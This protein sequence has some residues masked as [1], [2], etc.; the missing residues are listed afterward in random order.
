MLRSAQILLV[1]TSVVFVCHSF[2]DAYAQSSRQPDPGQRAG[3]TAAQ[4]SPQLAELLTNWSRAS[5]QIK[6]LH[7]RHT[8]RVYDTS[9][10]V[11]RISYGE[12]WFEA[13]DKGRIDIKAVE[14]TPKMRADRQ[15]KGAKVQRN[16][17]GVPFKLTSDQEAKWICDGQRVFD[18][19]EEEK[20]AQIANLP[21]TLRGKDI[22][23]SPLPFLFGMPPQEAIKRF[24][25]K[26]SKDYRPQHPY[27]I[28]EAL[29]LQRL[30]AENWSKAEIYLNTS[31]YLPTSVKLLDPGEKSSTVYT[32]TKIEVNQGNGFIN[33]VLG[34]NPFK[35]D[36]KG[37]NVQVIEQGQ[38]NMANASENGRPQNGINAQGMK[39][40]SVAMIPNVIG[41]PHAEAEQLLLNAGVPKEMISKQRG[42]PPKNPADTY[43]VRDQ[44]PKAGTPLATVLQARKKVALLIYEKL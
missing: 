41:R 32:F 40:A 2:G 6:T 27:V 31:T 14:I 5:D 43:K 36:L 19:N 1:V 30:D 3:N 35:P 9:F 38:N 8:R 37:Y 4:I 7:G 39:P 42:G 44:N 20:R 16:A 26:I 33:T 34:R 13:P 24:D 18:I 11:E 12:V 10:G 21:P 25:M 22:M 29:P 23:N 15:A 17:E 28:L